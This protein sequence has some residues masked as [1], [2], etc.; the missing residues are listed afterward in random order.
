MTNDLRGRLEQKI[1]EEYENRAGHL[2]E[3]H[4]QSFEEYK[5]RIGFLRGL[6]FVLDVIPDAE[7]EIRED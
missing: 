1:K 2:I 6:R 5:E 3:G 4:A 7:R